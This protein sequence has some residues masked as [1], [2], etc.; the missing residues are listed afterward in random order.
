MNIIYDNDLAVED[1]INLRASVGWTMLSEK[2]AQAG[3]S[4]CGFVIAAK[5]GNRTVGM[6]RVLTDGGCIAFILDVVVHPEYQGN[7]IGKALMQAVMNY[8]DTRIEVGEI[9]QVCLMAAKGKESFYTKFG[10]EERPND[11][12][13]AGMNQWIKREM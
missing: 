9:S 10:F 8:V 1:Y 4:G 5:D 12:S 2:Q 3:I 7:G 6:S 13:G 11:K